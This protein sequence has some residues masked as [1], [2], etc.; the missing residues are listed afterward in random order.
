MSRIQALRHLLVTSHQAETPGFAASIYKYSFDNSMLI[1]AQRPDAT[2]LA[3]LSL[4]NQLGCYVK[5]GEKSISVCDFQQGSPT[6]SHLFNV[7][8]TTGKQIP[9]L[10][11]LEQLDTEEL[12]GR[13]TSYLN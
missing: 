4:W 8:Q 3:P 1:Y 7:S 10:W 13:L 5:R 2:M 12:A 11:S 9:A 6:L